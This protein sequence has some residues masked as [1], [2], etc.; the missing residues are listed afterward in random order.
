MDEK[1]YWHNEPDITTQRDTDPEGAAS[2]SNSRERYVASMDI[3]ERVEIV[4]ADGTRIVAQFWEAKG[5]KVIL[6]TL[7]IGQG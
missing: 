7:P 3:G 4:K 5:N 6:R 1:G 2:R